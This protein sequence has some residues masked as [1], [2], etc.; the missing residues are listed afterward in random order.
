[1]SCA[2]ASKHNYW[3]NIVTR[4][5]FGWKRNDGLY[6]LF[7]SRGSSI[8]PQKGVEDSVLDLIKFKLFR[9]QSL[10]YIF[11]LSTAAM[12][13]IGMPPDLLNTCAYLHRDLPS[14]PWPGFVERGHLFRMDY[15]TAPPNCSFSDTIVIPS[16][17]TGHIEISCSAMGKIDVNALVDR[18]W[19]RDVVPAE[20]LLHHV[21]QISAT[22]GQ[23]GI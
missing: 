9:E 16:N 14:I 7:H 2:R 17:L 20:N 15:T 22:C 11:F 1:M 8:K 3:N 12:T 6:S 4:K 10:P 23:R 19:D 21:S 5:K 13:P 18:Y